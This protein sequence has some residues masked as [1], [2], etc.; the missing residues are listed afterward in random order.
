MWLSGTLLF[1]IGGYWLLRSLKDPIV[2]ATLGV[3]YI[4]KCK[5]AS[6][7]VVFTLVFV[8]NKLIDMMPKHK[9]FYVIGTF[10]AGVFSVIAMFLA[11]PTIGL[12]NTEVDP[13]RLI[14]WV[15]YCAIES[16]GSLGVTIFWAF[17]NSSVDLESAKSSFGLII[18]GAQFGAIGG[19]TLATMA[20]GLGIPFLYFCGAGCM[21]CIVFMMRIY[22]SKYGTVKKDK[23]DKKSAGVMEGAKLMLKYG[24][25]RGIFAISCL[26]MVEVTILD[27]MMKVL[28]KDE[29]ARRFPGDKGAATRG[30]AAFMGHFGQVTNTIS[31]TFS[32]LG[33]SFVIR[34]LGLKMTLLAF[35][36]MCLAAITLVY[37]CGP[38]LNTVFFAMIMLKGF[39]YALNN[40]TKE[41]LYQP[42]SLAVKF[43]AKSWIDIFGARGSKALGSVVTNALRS[44]VEGLL[45]LGSLVAMGISC[46]LICNAAY[47]GRK[48][49]QY[50]A[51]GHVVGGEDEGDNSEQKKEL[52]AQMVP[53]KEG[54]VE[55]GNGK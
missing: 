8:Y 32:L 7:V 45:S 31:L 38:C 53:L 3:E 4:P 13:T 14:G 50:Q 18:A 12:A 44:S 48:F 22:V 1:I 51:S 54:D 25:V 29:F 24:Y 16:F 28:A 30:F 40:P 6:L 46:M 10:Y 52:N 26:F 27:Y 17:V 2:A 11:H 15:S 34:R 21:L 9:L 39:S 37:M 42:T 23:K 55:Q 19:P 35:P 20:S 33:T 43:K 36:S 47:M 49:D 5:M 41:L